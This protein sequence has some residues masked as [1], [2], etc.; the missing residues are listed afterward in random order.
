MLL[1]NLPRYDNLSRMRRFTRIVF[2]T[3]KSVVLDETNLVEMT[4]NI[5]CS[6]FVCLLLLVTA[7]SVVHS[8][9]PRFEFGDA[10]ILVNNSYIPH[11]DIGE[12]VNDSNRQ[13]ISM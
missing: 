7:M 11:G 8:Q 4:D 2:E 9:C 1:H 3:Q 13:D 5:A 6:S 10:I 12:G